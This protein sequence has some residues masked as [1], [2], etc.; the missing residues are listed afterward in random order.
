[1]H[2]Y[3]SLSLLSR[4]LA[5][6]LLLSVLATSAFLVLLL[7]MAHLRSSTNEQ[8]RSKEVTAA[9]L[10][11]ER[12]VNQLEVSLRTFVVSGDD[13]F[14]SSWRL[15]R[16]N[17]AP[18][19]GT[20]E[21]VVANQ[22]GQRAA[23]QQLATAIRDYV[24]EY[25]L[26]LIAIAR[27]S[28]SGARAPVA[29]REGLNRINTIRHRLAQLQAHEDELAT[30]SLASAKHEAARAIQIGIASLVVTGGLLLLF[31]IFLAR[32]I[33]RPVRT[34]AEGAS[35]LAGGD[36]S[37]R[38]PEEGAAEIHEL[39]RSFNA[40]A[41]SLE[42]GKRELEAQNE[43]LR[44][45][46]RLKSELVSIVSHELRTP[47]ASIMGYTSLL[48]KR[49]FAK[50]DAE[51]YLEII[52]AQGSRLSSLVSEFLDVESVEAGRIELKD[53]LLDLK[54]LLIEEAQLIA[55]ET[56][57][58]QIQIAVAADSLPVRGDRDRL[59][60]VYGNLLTN[61][62]KYSPDGGL[63]EVVGEVEDHFVRIQVRD[64]GIGIPAEHQARIFTKFFRG[65]ARVS[66]IAGTGLGLAV[67]REIVEAHGGRIGFTS[68]PG[69]G[70]AFWFELPLVTN[71]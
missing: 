14:L 62:V 13:R 35:R 67:S 38:L 40:M 48:L 31:G 22:S 59:A 58:H 70:T 25:G 63:V 18:A 7:A 66:G 5:G 32:G 53:E 24:E 41:R 6:S 55:E 2:S 3:A 49:D 12:V 52:H 9:T 21:Q 8:A 71:D 26:P 64:E 29:T 46:E 11:L 1:M 33:A 45:S 47:L 20:L 27:V 17:L 19:I 28:P 15:A 16:G 44:Q 36:F 4:L 10:G 60:Q 69:K 50:A 56:K 51:H 65:E 23:V 37:I 43:Q 42:Q 57:N 68:E 54:Q 34:V 30:V 61:A 39:T